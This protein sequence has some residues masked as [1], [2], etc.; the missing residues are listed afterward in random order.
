MAFYLESAIFALY[1]NLHESWTLIAYC[2]LRKDFRLEG[3]LSSNML[4]EHF[5]PHKMILEQ[6]IDDYKKKADQRRNAIGLVYQHLQ[7]I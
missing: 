4:D 6:F 3:V 2:Q 1:N 7:I 5:P